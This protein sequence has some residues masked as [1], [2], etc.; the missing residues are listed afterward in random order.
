[1]Y[2][3]HIL[4]NKGANMQNQTYGMFTPEGNYMVARIVEAGKKLVELD[5]DKMNAWQ[6]ANR[7]LSK[8]GFAKDFE[9]A[10]DT[11]V[12]DQVHGAV[13]DNDMDIPFYI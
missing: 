4:N 13:T 12:R 7:E 2:N 5:G 10:T 1:M 8:L 3:I 11:D 9:E 6:F